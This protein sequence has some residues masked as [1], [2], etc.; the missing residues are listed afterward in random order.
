MRQL[1]VPLERPG[2]R[3]NLE[4]IFDKKTMENVNINTYINFHAYVVNKLRFL[5][6]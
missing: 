2:F 6:V 3:G 1:Q 5:L 4:I